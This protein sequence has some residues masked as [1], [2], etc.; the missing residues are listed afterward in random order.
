MTGPRLFPT[1]LLDERLPQARRLSIERA[2]DKAAR[3]LNLQLSTGLPRD[4]IARNLDQVEARSSEIA[5]NPEEYRRRN[6]FVAQ[7][8]AEHPDHVALA[9]EIGRASRRGKMA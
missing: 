7:W 1:E 5:T 4:F 6:P 2:P 3:I 9:Q 8:L